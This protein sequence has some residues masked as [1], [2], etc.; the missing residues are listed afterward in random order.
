MNIDKYNR[1]REA[2]G[3]ISKNCA[4]THLG[5]YCPFVKWGMV[6]YDKY[7]CALSGVAPLDW[8]EPKLK[9]RWTDQEKSA[10]KVLK[11]AGVV[12][13]KRD[14]AREMVVELFGLGM[15]PLGTVPYAMFPNLDYNKAVLL[16]DIIGE[17]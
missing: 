15:A 8:P 3:E 1:L 2:A 16:R 10:A 4:E 5:E 9:C 12:S 17:G 6:C 7:D 14:H 11:D 13:I